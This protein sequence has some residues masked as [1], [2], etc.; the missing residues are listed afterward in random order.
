MSRWT[1]LLAAVI[2]GMILAAGT[3]AVEAAAQ[4]EARIPAYKSILWNDDFPTAEKK[5]RELDVK[6]E[7]NK[8]YKIHDFINRFIE[9]RVVKSPDEKTKE[10]IFQHFGGNYISA[11]SKAGGVRLYFIFERPSGGKEAAIRTELFEVSIDYPVGLPVSDIL[12]KL[13]AEYGEPKIEKTSTENLAYL[14]QLDEI[15]KKRGY[16]GAKIVI[17]LTRHL[18]KKDGI[19][20]IF[21]VPDYKKTMLKFSPESEFKEINE[22]IVGGLGIIGEKAKSSIRI[23]LFEQKDKILPVCEKMVEA[24]KNGEPFTPEMRAIEDKCFDRKLVTPNMLT[25][26]NERLLDVFKENVNKALNQAQE[27]KKEVKDIPI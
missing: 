21:E 4:A 18:Y 8:V 1:V 16:F 13:E 24:L 15:P 26:I 17:P 10:R 3:F 12:E 11:S 6:I 2:S 27:K 5:L 9:E 23:E 7:D 14:K 25:K 20:I 19:A 22:R